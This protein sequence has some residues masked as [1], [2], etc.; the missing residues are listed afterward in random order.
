MSYYDD[1]VEFHRA[2]EAPAPTEVTMPPQDRMY[3][4]RS[5]I[6]EEYKEV[7]ESMIDMLFLG[8][9]E[10]PHLMK[11]LADLIVVCLGTAV[12]FGISFDE[13]WKE[14]HRSN[15]SKLGPNGEV[16]RRS[17]GKVLKGEHYTPADVE[18]VLRAR[19]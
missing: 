9:S 11:E 10:I 7:M 6:T 1:I 13:V 14:V 16:L 17:D 3:L 4:R 12:E 15:M 5:L 18:A 19:S 2:F 8:E